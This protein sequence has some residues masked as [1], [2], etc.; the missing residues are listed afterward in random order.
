M[1]APENV[2]LGYRE[3]PE[4][5][6]R[7]ICSILVDKYPDLFEFW[8]GEAGLGKGFRPQTI[9]E[10][11]GENGKRLDDCLFKPGEGRFAKDVLKLTVPL[12][13]ENVSREYW[14][15]LNRLKD[16]MPEEELLR[17]AAGE[18]AEAAADSPVKGLF[19]AMIPWMGPRWLR[20][21]RESGEPERVDDAAAAITS[22]N[23]LQEKVKSLKASWKKL[24]RYEK[25]LL[26]ALPVETESLE[27]ALANM[28]TTGREIREAI[29]KLSVEEGY[30][31]KSW[32]NADELKARLK[33]IEDHIKGK[34]RSKCNSLLKDIAGVL[35]KTEVRHR[36]E[37]IRETL[38][39]TK[40]KACQSL[41][42]LAAK[43]QYHEFPGLK[44]EGGTE[45]IDWV[46]SHS[47][48]EF[49]EIIDAIG[50]LTPELAELMISIGRDNLV[51]ATKT[52][53]EEPAGEKAEESAETPASAKD[54]GPAPGGKP[55]A[56]EREGAYKGPAA[57]DEAVP[58]P[59]GHREEDSGQATKPEEPPRGAEQAP[60]PAPPSEPVKSATT[61][62]EPKSPKPAR[63]KKVRPADPSPP[64]PPEP[65]PARLDFDSTKGL[66]EAGTSIK[67]AIAAVRTA[68]GQPK[69][70]SLLERLAWLLVLHDRAGTGYH[71]LRCLHG[72]QKG[73]DPDVSHHLLRMAILG[74]LVRFPSGKIAQILQEDY[75]NTE[76]LDPKKKSPGARL[77]TQFLTVAAAL[78]PAL[79][80]PMTGLA[81]LLAYDSNE[82]GLEGFYNLRGHLIEFTKIHRPL[83]PTS[84]KSVNDK[85]QWENALTELKKEVREWI[86]QAP[87]R[88]ILYQPAS[89]VWRQWVESGGL[90]YRLLQPVSE[91]SSK[92][93]KRTKE[94]IEKLRDR[95]KVLHLVKE[96]NR[97][98]FGKKIKI[99][100]RALDSLNRKVVEA[101][102][103]AERW[104][105]LLESPP[106]RKAEKYIQ[107]MVLKLKS[108]LARDFEAVFSELSWFRSNN[109]D[110]MVVASL[111][112][113]ESALRELQNL[114]DPDLPLPDSEP[115]PLREVNADLLKIPGISLDDDWD[116]WALKEDEL[117]EALLGRLPAQD[118]SW[119]EAFRVQGEERNH[120]A[121]GLILELMTGMVPDEE[122]ENLARKREEEIV[123]C[124][125]ALQRDLDETREKLDQA[126]WAGLLNESEF[127]D[128]SS[129]VQGID[130]RL[131]EIVG[132]ARAHDTLKEIRDDIARRSEAEAE[133]VKLRLDHE[134]KKGPNY[135]RILDLIKSGDTATASEY[136]EQVKSGKD[137]TSPVP[138]Y[139]TMFDTFFPGIVDEFSSWLDKTS[140]PKVI[141]RIQNGRTIAGMEMEHVRSIQRQEAAEMM[142]KWYTAKQR[143]RITAEEIQVILERIGFKNVTATC[144][145]RPQHR[146]TSFD[147]SCNS[148][149]DREVC[150]IP[151]FGSIARGQYRVICVF[152]RPTED[153]IVGH[154]V[155]GHMTRP[156]IVLFFGRMSVQA[157]RDLALL[158]HSQKKTLLVVDDILM[159]FLCGQRGSRL[160]VLFQCALPFTSCDPYVTSASVIPP[161]MLYGRTTERKSIINPMGTNFIYG[162]RQ[163][164]KTV[165][166]RDI[167]HSLHEPAQGR[168]VIWIDLKAEGVGVDR[169]IWPLIRSML[170]GTGD[171]SE[172]IGRRITAEG[173][174][175]GIEEWLD[176]DPDRRILL[177]LD[178]A[179]TF[180]KTD[181]EGGFRETESI[182][183]LN[184]KTRGRFKPVFVGLHNVRRSSHGIIE[185]TRLGHLNVPL[186]I[187]PLLGQ[188]EGRYARQL[189]EVPMRS[190][191]YRFESQELV[192]RILSQTNYYPSLIQLY[193]S[194]LLEHL[195][196]RS[197]TFD[198]RSCPPYLVTSKMVEETYNSSKLRA[199][200]RYRFH[201]TLDLDRRYRAIALGIAFLRLGEEEMAA[202]VGFSVA[203]VR[204][205]VLNWWPQ[206]FKDSNSLDA[207]GVLL[208]EMTNLGVLREVSPGRFDLRTS[209]LMQLIG[210]KETIETELLELSYSEPP[211]GFEVSHLRAQ[212]KDKCHL[213]NPL[214]RQQEAMLHRRRDGT[215]I[216]FGT[217][218]AGLDEVARFT[219]YRYPGRYSVC[220]GVPDRAEFSSWLLTA[221]KKSSDGVNIILVPSESPWNM[222]WLDEAQSSLGRRRSSR[223]ALQVVFLADPDITMQ[224]ISD[225]PELIRVLERKQ[226]QFMG[227][228]PWH[229]IAVRHWLKD[230]GL[231][232]PLGSI[233]HRKRVRE[234][235]GYWHL[236]MEKLYE[237]FQDQPTERERHLGNLGGELLAPENVENHLELFGLKKNQRRFRIMLDMVMM[238]KEVS[239]EEVIREE[240]GG[241]ED[242]EDGEDVGLVNNVFD[243]ADL[244]RL[245]SPGKD[246]SYTMDP[247]VRKL[248]ENL[249]SESS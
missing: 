229:D 108:H 110:L 149:E 187:G 134:V 20:P 81:S 33:A 9:A 22:I 221:A 236:F 53:A 224:L 58:A 150:P 43:N 14:E 141:R 240:G 172:M 169:E 104:V 36:S 62:Q 52:D 106:G 206:G 219:K 146:A 190:L 114:F 216:V 30:P 211:P 24:S 51:S 55:A 94:L 129:R 131:D 145:S 164:G 232:I 186:C 182:L 71:V 50:K 86:Y 56:E 124:R 70:P 231:E 171:L 222:S 7:K 121:T 28:V 181:G 173:V 249:P 165:L 248:M 82:P 73:Y 162:G 54:S 87:N 220:P 75:S 112:L 234:A 201:L 176:I 123:N 19:T 34:R 225:N 202:D 230:C 197:H 44:S 237:E 64:E 192:A 2:I 151:R 23:E 66:I 188:G 125:A 63:A 35:E 177:L 163:L 5:F 102:E 12:L 100:A 32:R 161:E 200:I 46:F 83:D 91:N 245:I 67:K 204:Q 191:G 115:S 61:R 4:I 133:R 166:L 215:A 45:W 38:Q 243:W 208:E 111:E 144:Q 13:D 189:I 113:C 98:K 76:A 41:L 183:S 198:R 127:T 241:E 180:F 74:K 185:N 193:C 57:K 118:L 196:G 107:D 160:P 210:T 158:C 155:Q 238:G 116:T 159:L 95:D 214:T 39:S 25:K 99:E 27:K 92:G 175:A 49:D 89:R 184:Q 60:A 147:V 47:G 168:I 17:E 142:Q 156:V 8:R 242:G 120:Q 40:N 69:Y 195:A 93:L 42:A 136:I 128:K 15:I 130:D 6:K 227:L 65:S 218:S 96:E 79:L 135:D 205:E 137:I 209:N 78:K 1:S 154:C 68:A 247:L 90:V 178:E 122:H 138:V 139:S 179:D 85:V 109:N 26:A 3:L 10:R 117:L 244:L 77:A 167:A 143:Q 174:S 132:F 72:L 140:A 21:N 80:S 126:L 235:T 203:R 18:L 48:R 217:R 152:G 199:E 31:P 153:E 148:V 239:P 97:K 228:G 194:H 88:T 59:E 84:L 223:V 233:D 37:K 105:S 103:L 157:R 119:E 226:V 29:K 207:I 170:S 16:Q 11:K 101:V 246:G 213:L 212:Y